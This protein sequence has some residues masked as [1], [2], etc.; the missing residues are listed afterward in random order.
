MF[1]EIRKTYKE[2]H[3]MLFAG[4]ICLALLSVL[5]LF[6]DRRKR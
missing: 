6:G 3:F 1:D 2:A 4:L 5:A